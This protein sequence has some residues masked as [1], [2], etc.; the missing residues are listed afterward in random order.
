MICPIFNAILDGHKS[1]DPGD[2]DSSCENIISRKFRCSGYLAASA[3][4]EDNRYA[5][6]C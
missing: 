6:S 4:N 1:I 2:A 3:E 5:L